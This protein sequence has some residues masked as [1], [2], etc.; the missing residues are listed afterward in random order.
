MEYVEGMTLRD[1]LKERGPLPVGE[2]LELLSQIADG[3]AAGWERGVVHRD[4]KPSNIM[5]DARG[6][7]RVADFG[8]AKPLETAETRRSPTAPGWWHAAVHIARAGH[9]RDPRPAER[10]LHP[11]IV[12]WRCWKGGDRS[13]G[14]APSP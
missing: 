7:A 9:G 3:L 5:I 2:A 11:G 14:P 12:L 10:H 1:L 8:L 13:R 6:R 4:V